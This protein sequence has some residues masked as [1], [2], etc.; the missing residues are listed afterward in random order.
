MDGWDSRWMDHTD[1][2]IMNGDT[3][4]TDWMDADFT[5]AYL[6]N[7]T[8]LAGSVEHGPLWEHLPLKY[9]RKRINKGFTLSNV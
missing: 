8:Y 1:G 2:W 5:S 7:I 6:T 3:D 4:A 9:E